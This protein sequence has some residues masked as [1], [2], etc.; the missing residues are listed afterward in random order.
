MKRL[1]FIT[2]ALALLGAAGVVG[3]ADQRA[4]SGKNGVAKPASSQVGCCVGCCKTG[5]H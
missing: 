1:A 5:H 3:A 2:T 4:K